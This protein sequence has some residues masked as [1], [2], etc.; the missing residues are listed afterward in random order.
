MLARLQDSSARRGRKYQ[1]LFDNVPVGLYQLAADA[2][3]LEA[4]PALAAMLGYDDPGELTGKNPGE[5]FVRP[6]ELPALLTRVI[7]AGVVQG[8]EVALRR[9]DGQG[10]WVRASLRAVRDAHRGVVGFEGAVEDVSE[11]RLAETALQEREERFRKIFHGSPHPI[12]IYDFPDARYVDV[13]REFERL[14]GYCREEVLG[15]TTI[16]LGLWADPAEAQTVMEEALR[17]GFVRDREVHI[18]ARNGSVH[19]LLLSAS[20]EMLGNERYIVSFARDITERKRTE[21]ML[22]GALERAEESDR[23]KTAFVANMSHEIRTPLNVILGYTNVV[24]EYLEDVKGVPSDLL[25]RVQRAGDRLL[26]TI[27]SVLD[28]SR[29]EA[30]SFPIAPRRIELASFLERLVED[31]RLVADRKGL[32]VQLLPENP[33]ATAIVDEYCLAQAVGN[34]IEN[35]IKFTETGGVT[36]RLSSESDATAVIAVSDT[37]KGI[38]AK[39]LPHLFQ[40]FSQ[41]DVGLT[42]RYEGAGLGLALVKRYVELNGGELSVDSEKTRGAVFRIRFPSG[43]VPSNATG[44]T[45]TGHRD[46]I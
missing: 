44:Q 29:M 7:E 23:L 34:L 9:R 17:N 20:L 12:T 13:N 45:G 35:A 39:F 16:E 30:K 27:Q 11:R 46:Q 33:A 22:R 38:E 36:L 32:F 3:I 2:T 31:F 4:N 43:Y 19:T 8:E 10:I 18:R 28:M 24:A 1:D 37:G 41:E 25:E 6:G 42:R 26:R 14:T 5:L 15:R 21:E 40:P